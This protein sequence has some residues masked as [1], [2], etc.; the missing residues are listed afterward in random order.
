MNTPKFI[1][2]HD[3]AEPLSINVSNIE[4]FADETISLTD[5][6]VRV[7]ESYDEIK[8]L[9]TGQKSEN[10]AEPLSIEDLRNMIGKP[11]Y[12]KNTERWMLVEEV[13]DDFVKC[14]TV[15]DIYKYRTYS[16]IGLE[17]AKMLYRVEVPTY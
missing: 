15:N 17:K 6:E 12:D 14:K 13:R 8:A 2:V 5:S 4:W 1:E 7:V 9:V 16:S 11:V 10:T 3:G